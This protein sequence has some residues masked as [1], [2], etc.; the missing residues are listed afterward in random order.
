[1]LSIL[2]VD[3]DES[4]TGLASRIL[5]EAGYDVVVASSGTEALEILKLLSPDIVITDLVMP[6]MEGLELIQMLVK[7]KP[8]LK[9]IAI[10][11]QFGGLF[12]KVAES[13]GAKST[14]EKPFSRDELLEVVA[15]VAATG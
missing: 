2:F 12:L 1:M 4:I 13:F 5:T 7:S 14:L 15:R 8:G 11:G 3:D 6:Y 9:L 10:S